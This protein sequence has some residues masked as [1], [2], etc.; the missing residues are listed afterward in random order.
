[1]VVLTFLPWDYNQ[2]KVKFKIKMIKCNIFFLLVLILNWSI[3][4]N[5]Y[6]YISTDM[7]H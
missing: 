7:K 4:I 3:K 2:R 1:M 6:L 5:N